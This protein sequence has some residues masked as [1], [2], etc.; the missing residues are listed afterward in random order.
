MAPPLPM[1]SLR[2][3]VQAGSSGA[4]PLLSRMRLLQ[5]TS[6]LR[7]NL[8]SSSSA[9]HQRTAPGGLQTHAWEAG[10]TA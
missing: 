8:L 4:A 9:S 5:A 6:A 3:F 10:T 2:E 1:S 7:R